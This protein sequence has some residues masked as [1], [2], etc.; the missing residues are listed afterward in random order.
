[1]SQ[2]LRSHIDVDS[3][4]LLIID[5]CYLP[6]KYHQ[7]GGDALLQKPLLPYKY[8][9]AQGVGLD[10]GGDGSYKVRLER[11]PSGRPRRLVIEFE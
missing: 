4:R 7:A 5:P 10:A 1:M 8:K 3:G 2:T 9:L 6:A 11:H